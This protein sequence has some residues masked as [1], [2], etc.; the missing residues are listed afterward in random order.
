MS[1]GYARAVSM[2]IDTDIL[3]WALRGSARAAAAI[4]K[5]ANRSLSVVN[6]MELVQGARN[7]TELSMLRAS[8][9]RM[10]FRIVPLSEN[11][12]HRASV[13]VEEYALKSGLQLAG[14]LV[15]ATAVEKGIPLF[16]GNVRHY[17]SITDLQLKAFR[18]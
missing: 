18:P 14:A 8:L 9:T 17:R 12:G 6:Y 13:Y 2:L 3:I 15:A 16:S 7:K 11:I 1:A 5:T 10:N 4:N